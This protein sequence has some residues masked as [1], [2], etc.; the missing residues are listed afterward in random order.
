LHPVEVIDAVHLDRTRQLKKRH[1]FR[2]R[3][4]AGRC[5]GSRQDGG[6]ATASRFPSTFGVALAIADEVIE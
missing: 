1:D 2:S 6:A 4:S 5:M 3:L